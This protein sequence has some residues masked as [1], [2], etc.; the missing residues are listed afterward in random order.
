MTEVPF[1]E[2]AGSN[3]EIG[4]LLGEYSRERLREFMQVPRVV[5]ERERFLA[6]PDILSRSLRASADRYPQYLDE[7]RGIAEGVGLRLEDIFIYNWRPRPRTLEGDAREGADAPSAE[8]CTT[9]IVPRG[10]RVLLAHNEDWYAGT[11]DI[12]V[13]RLRYESGLDF[14]GVCYHGFLPGLSASINQW[15]LVQALNS[16]TSSDGRAGVPLALIYRASLEAATI[17][18]AVAVVTQAG[19]ADSENFDFAQGPRAVFVETSAADF[20][21]VEVSKPTVHTNHFLVERLKPLEA[22]ERLESTL[23]RH[24]RATALLADLEN[25]GPDD[26]RAILSSHEDWPTS[27]CRHGSEPDCED[28]CD[29]LGAIIADTAER[30]LEVCYGPPCRSKFKRFTL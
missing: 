30:T 21:L 9:L 1:V 22:S 19:R 16:L 11:N 26:L 14:L 17:D 25:P 20:E 28:H 6:R 7:M 2:F 12:F 29:T 27:I 10:E 4:R 18:E 24:A 5:Q 15:G 23:A 3:F 8:G 13:A